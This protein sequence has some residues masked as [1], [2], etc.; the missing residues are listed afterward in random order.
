MRLELAAERSAINAL[1]M[2]RDERQ[3]HDQLVLD[4][5]DRPQPP[6]LDD[7]RLAAFG[8]AFPGPGLHQRH[9]DPRA[10]RMRKPFEATLTNELYD[11]RVLE[12]NGQPPTA[13]SK[14]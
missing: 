3:R 5:I 2:T 13:L 7:Q 1:R 9:L 8:D 12:L 4:E 6:L 10:H 14:A 11:P